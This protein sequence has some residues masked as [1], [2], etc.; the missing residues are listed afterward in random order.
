MRLAQASAASYTASVGNVSSAIFRPYWGGS[1][2]RLLAFDVSNPVSPKLVSNVDLSHTGYSGAKDLDGY[3]NRWDW[4]APF[5]DGSRVFLSHQSYVNRDILEPV[6]TTDASGALVVRE[7]VS[8]QPIQR[9]VSGF[10][11]DVIDYADPAAPDVGDPVNIPGELKG[12]GEAGTLLYTAGFA[13]SLTASGYTQ[14]WQYSL[15]AS[16][17]DGALAHL[18]AS[19]PIASSYALAINANSVFFVAAANES[20]S[21]YDLQAWKLDGDQNFQMLDKKPLNAGASSLRLFG[22]LLAV[23]TWNGKLALFDATD[24]GALQVIDTEAIDASWYT[25]VENATGAIDRGLWRP[26]GPYGVQFIELGE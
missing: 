20:G 6:A 1:S 4:S 11:L 19:Q 23:Q 17:Y 26:L 14:T 5:V 8:S 13:P 21:S 18:I 9:F 12:L 22:D 3:E 7:D 2:E 16:N 15:Q 24:A 25:D 10:F